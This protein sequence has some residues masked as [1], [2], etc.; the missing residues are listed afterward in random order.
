MNIPRLPG[1]YRWIDRTGFIGTVNQEYLIPV[2]DVGTSL[3]IKWL[4]LREP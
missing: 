4:A 3:G 1:T 2:E